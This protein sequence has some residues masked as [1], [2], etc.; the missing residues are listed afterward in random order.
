MSVSPF[1]SR[2]KHVFQYL[3][4]AVLVPV[5]GM[6]SFALGKYGLRVLESGGY[7]DRYGF[8][9][10]A[11]APISYW[12]TLGSTALLTAILAFSAV[13]FFRTLLPPTKK[14]LASRDQQRAALIQSHLATQRM[15]RE[16][17]SLINQAKQEKHAK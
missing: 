10:A 17:E 16:L 15:E 6:G 5:F 12:L 3:F 14:Q 4:R 9:T 11:S 13:V 2:Y 1:L 7:S 8:T